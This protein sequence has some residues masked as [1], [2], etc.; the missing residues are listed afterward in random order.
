MRARA[1]TTAR[2]S[3]RLQTG[4]HLQL[5]G[6]PLSNAAPQGAVPAEEHLPIVLKVKVGAELDGGLPPT[7]GK[8]GSEQ[9][10]GPLPPLLR[11]QWQARLVGWING[12]RGVLQPARG[13]ADP[14]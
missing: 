11:Q 4:H 5:A 2:D 14:P 7:R 10:E 1:V 8:R 12:V 6:H 9:T 3:A 13:R